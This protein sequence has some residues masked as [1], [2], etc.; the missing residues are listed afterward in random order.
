MQ[1]QIHKAET[2]FTIILKASLHNTMYYSLAQ[3]NIWQTHTIMTLSYILT[4]Y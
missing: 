2:N 4:H 1:L 3:R